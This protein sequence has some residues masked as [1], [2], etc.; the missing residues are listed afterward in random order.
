VSFAVLLVCTGN[1]CRSP[2]AERL[3]RARVDGH[4]PIVTASAG[5]A[6]LVGYPIDAPSATVLR[7]LGGDPERHAGQRLSARLVTGADLILT[8]EASHRSVVVQGDPI[9][10]RRAF[11]LREFGRLGAG[12][13]PLDGPPTVAALRARV[14]AVAQRRGIVEPVDPGADDIGDPFG[15][16]IKVA[17]AAGAQVSEAVDEVLAALGLPHS[18]AAF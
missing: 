13:G 12:L 17:R 2:M 7:E 10:F 6:G 1:I 16:P 11:T 9:A 14:G 8:A 5:V 15:A 18:G 3:F 4:T